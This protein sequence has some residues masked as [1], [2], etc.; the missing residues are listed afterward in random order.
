M[1]R[2]QPFFGRALRRA[3][4][5]TGLKIT[6]VRNPHGPGDEPAKIVRADKKGATIGPAHGS[7]EGSWGL[8]PNGVM[9][10]TPSLPIRFPRRAMMSSLSLGYNK[11]ARF[12]TASRS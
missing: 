1:E 7:Q 6:E 10:R 8:T 5:Q 9:R 3:L 12:I 4:K 11:P 2:D